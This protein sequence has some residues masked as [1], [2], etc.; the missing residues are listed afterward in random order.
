[1]SLTTDTEIQIENDIVDTFEMWLPFVELR[2]INIDLSEQGKNKMNI[3]IKFN[4]RNAPTDLQSVG[5]VVE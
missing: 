1:M 2:E 4:I 5:V 3:E